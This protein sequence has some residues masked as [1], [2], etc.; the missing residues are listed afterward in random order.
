MPAEL[1]VHHPT[2]DENAGM[3]LYNVLQARQ[4]SYDELD[5]AIVEEYVHCFGRLS[6]NLKH[7][8]PLFHDN[9]NFFRINKRTFFEVLIATRASSLFAF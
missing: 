7:N 6:K 9:P 5:A 1:C 4:V 3:D 2:N 8:C